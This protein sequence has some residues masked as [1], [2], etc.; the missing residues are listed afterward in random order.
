M[1]ALILG[2]FRL[3]LMNSGDILIIILSLLRV[4]LT[5]GILAHIPSITFVD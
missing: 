5:L 4:V 3:N 2:P 1:R